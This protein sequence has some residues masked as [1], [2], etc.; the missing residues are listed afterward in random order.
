MNI[1]IKKWV[2]LQESGIPPSSIS[3][4]NKKEYSQQLITLINEEIE[5]IKYENSKSPLLTF[6]L[7]FDYQEDNQFFITVKN[8]I[9]K[10]F[11]KNKLDIFKND[12]L[13]IEGAK[14]RFKTND[15]AI[16]F[17]RNVKYHF[18]NGKYQIQLKESVQNY[19]RMIAGLIKFG[20][21]NLMNQSIMQMLLGQVFVWDI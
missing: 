11:E 17:C 5:T 9:F 20:K 13:I 3:Y 12:I 7:E 18:E 6:D 21:K 16:L 10:L 14:V 4:R 15:S 19:E 2:K 8:P 1:D